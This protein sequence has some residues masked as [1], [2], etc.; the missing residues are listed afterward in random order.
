LLLNTLFG[1][2]PDIWRSGERR[3]IGQLIALGRAD[4]AESGECR[5]ALLPNGL[6]LDKREDE[7]WAQAWLAVANKHAGLDKL[8]T[9]YSS[10]QGPKRSQILGQLRRVVGGI[11]HK[12][13]RSA[14]PLRFAG[15]QSRYLLI[16]P[17]F[18]PSL[19]EE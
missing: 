15:V 4:E 17:L 16:P 19:E 7:T 6:R 9:G 12:A 8:L 5:K 1:L 11:E 3:T 10:Y 2:A 13:Q 18:L 14:I